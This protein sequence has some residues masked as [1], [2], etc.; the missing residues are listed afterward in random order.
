MHTEKLY[1]ENG[2]SFTRVFASDKV[3][4][5]NPVEYYKTFE[6]QRRMISLRDILSIENAILTAQLDD[7]YFRRKAEETLVGFFEKFE[8]TKVHNNFIKLL[9]TERKKDQIRLLKG[10]ILNPDQLMALI[11]KSFNDFGY[12]YSKYHFKNLPNGF[13]GKKL[14]KIFHIKEDG[15]IDQTGDTDLS[16]GEL[17]HVIDHRKVIVSHF[18]E[19]DNNWHCFFLTYNSIGGRENWKNGQPH[20]HYIS[21]AFGISKDDFIESMQTGKYRS[22]PVHIDLLEYGKQPDKE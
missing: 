2:K 19:N 18:F 4:N 8:N 1:D 15:S 9:Q 3:E 22:T 10:M 7:D 13:E 17:K 12:L 6:L 16:D 11:F 5:V 20:F 21:S 14:P